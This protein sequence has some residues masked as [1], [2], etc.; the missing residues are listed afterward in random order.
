MRKEYLAL[1]AAG[2]VA[3]NAA[4]VNYDL[5]GR[6]DS[7]MNSP[8]VYK[9]VDYSKMKKNEEQNIGSSLVTKA[10]AKQASGIKSGAKAIVGWA[11]P[12]GYGFKE[13]PNGK[14]G[15]ASFT[16]WKSYSSITDYINKANKSFIPVYSD[17]LPKYSDLYSFQSGDATR[18]GYSGFQLTETP[19]AMPADE[20]YSHASSETINNL[21]KRNNDAISNVG[22]YLSED[23]VPVRLNQYTDPNPI[24]PFII[25]ETNEVLETFSTMPGSEMRA[26]RTYKL[27]H[28]FSDRSVVYVT[29]N[30]PSDPADHSHGPQVYMGVHDYGGS[31]KSSYN[32]KAQSLDNYIYNKRTIELV[33]A[34][35]TPNKLSAEAFAVNAI[36]V[37][38]LDPL[39]GNVASY[40]GKGGEVSCCYEEDEYVKP[41]IYNYSNFYIDDFYRTYSSS[42]H[43]YYYKPFYEGTEAA[44]GVTAGMVSNMLSKNPFYK[45]HPEVVKAVMLNAKKNSLFNY[46]GLVNKKQSSRSDHEYEHFSMYFI[47][48]V[49]SLMD[50]IQT[51]GEGCFNSLC[52]GK[53]D[54]V[55]RFTTAQ[56]AKFFNVDPQYLD[57]IRVAISWLNSGNDIAKLGDVPQKYKI[58]I[59]TRHGNNY[60]FTLR[61]W[62]DGEGRTDYSRYPI[63]PYRRAA[64]YDYASANPYNYGKISAPEYK[65]QIILD[66]EDLNSE[67][68]G[69]MVLGVD[70][71]PVIY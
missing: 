50:N 26:S 62:S 61:D 22:L 44:T 66:E 10:L 7:K 60:N 52:S 33:A 15:C 31:A 24:A 2:C 46:D 25:N 20:F 13:C 58:N 12:N 21:L 32:S 40:S 45:W 30:R 42:S 53:K 68:Y 14:S 34:G 43:T 29:K 28:H 11:G 48:D 49:N 36:T 71:M 56:L 35:N 70:I 57:G 59:Y 41:D 69:Q 64:A 55:L 63:Y 5:L 23:A 47:G 6:K 19:Y 51:E 17:D 16:P 18:S 4:N 3:A 65:I 38:A 8:M 37:G 27:V 39:T 54:L 1:L 9:N 67:N